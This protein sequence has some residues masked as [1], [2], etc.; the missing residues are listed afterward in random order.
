MGGRGANDSGDGPCVRTPLKSRNVSFRVNFEITTATI[1][2]LFKFVL[3]EFTSSS[4]SVDGDN[5]AH[6]P[7]LTVS[8]TS[9]VPLRPFPSATVSLNLYIPSTRLDSRSTA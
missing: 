6:I 5:V 1:I 9:S 8:N 3:P 4:F 2:S 7:S